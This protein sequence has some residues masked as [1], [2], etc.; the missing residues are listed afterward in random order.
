MSDLPAACLPADPPGRAAD[1]VPG[2]AVDAHVHML[3]RDPAYPLFDGRVEDPGPGDFD[4]W[5]ERY[6]RHRDTLGFRRTV[7]VQS[8]LHGLDNA[9][10]LDAVRAL[11][12]RT[13]RAV[14]LV[15]EDVP[16]RALDDLAGAGARAIRLNH[17]HGGVLSWAGARRLAPRLAARG[18]HLEMLV[19]AHRH[20][21][22]LAADLDRFPVPVVFD[23]VA[24]PDVMLGPSEPGFAALCDLVRRGRAWV[25]LS[26]LYRLCPAPY[27]DADPLVAA[28]VAAGP[29]RCVWGSDWPHVMLADAAM[30]DAGTLLD[31]LARAVPDPA[32]RARILTTN[33]ERLYGFA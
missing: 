33:A 28:L 11:G 7:F 8:I 3:A 27:A 22:E 17:V 25:K 19:H 23:H 5:M 16:E 12:P 31:A 15:A 29:G 4:T 24:W 6:R 13:A 1:P 21:L 32:C 18:M 14:V 10:T 2:Q 20:I 9:I 26:G 30:P